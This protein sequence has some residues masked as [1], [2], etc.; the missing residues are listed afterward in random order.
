MAVISRPKG[1]VVVIS[2][3]Y[4]A[5]G[6]AGT[7][8][9]P[10][11]V[12]SSCVTSGIS[13]GSD[14]D[15]YFEWRG[16]G[17]P[18][19]LIVGG[20][21]DC[22]YY[23]GLAGILADE[24]T[25]LSY[26]RRGNSRSTL[27]GDPA[28]LVMSEQSADALAVLDANGIAS[29]LV[30]G[31]S[32]GATIALDLAAHHPERVVAAVVHEPPVPAVLPDPEGYLAIYDEMDRLLEVAG[33]VAAFRYFQA[34]IGQVPA[35]IIAALLDPGP[36]LPP[37]PRRD[38]MQRV[39]GNWEYMTRYE[40]RSFI[41]YQPDLGRIVANGTPI[42]LAC[43]ADTIDAEAVR[44]SRVAAARLGTDCVVFPGGHTAPLEIPE[45]FGPVLRALLRTFTS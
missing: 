41:D 8:H 4:R 43:G 30:F 12:D 19:L 23:D 32:G 16:S 25:V 10:V 3:R 28:P 9:L 42:A 36:H 35:P 27:R 2:E 1:A 45:A 6:A 21:G 29:A 44:M 34:T 17:P 20:G 24:F 13:A 7:R 15:L 39:S 11:P 5:E 26:D 14:C 38:L 18:L 22:G 33:W 40:I 31:N 37:G